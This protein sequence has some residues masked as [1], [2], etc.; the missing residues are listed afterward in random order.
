MEISPEMREAVKV[1]KALGEPTRLNIVKLLAIEP[2][3]CCVSLGEKL[4]TV[5]NSTLS[6]HLKQLSECGLLDSRKEGTFIYYS[7]NRSV[8]EKYAPYL[9]K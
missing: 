5:A 1:Y 2:D 4:K 6:H 9:L 3:Q 8:A 7:L